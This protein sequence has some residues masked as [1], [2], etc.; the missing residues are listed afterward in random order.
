MAHEWR[1]W[2][3]AKSRYSPEREFESDGT[4]DGRGHAN[5]K[6]RLT[7]PMQS[8]TWQLEYNIP[9]E[10]CQLDRVAA[11]VRGFIDGAGAN[12]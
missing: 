7:P 12:R 6:F 3:E 5:L 8:P 11:E 2:S 10:A 1:G 4:D 9:I